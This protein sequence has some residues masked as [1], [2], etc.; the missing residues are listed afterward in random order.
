MSEKGGTNVKLMK[1][2]TKRKRDKTLAIEAAG[3]KDSKAKSAAG[4]SKS[5]RNPVVKY[6]ADRMPSFAKKPESKSVFHLALF[7]TSAFVIVKYGSQMNK[8]IEGMFPST[9]QLMAQM[10]EQQAM[11]MPPPPM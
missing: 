3:A 7:A 5:E 11:M 9:E 6:I 8:L 4:S 10:K 1:Q 2:L